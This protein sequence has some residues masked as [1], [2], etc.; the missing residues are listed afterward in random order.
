VVSAVLLLFPLF[1]S[2]VALLTVAVLSKVVAAV[3]SGLIFTTRLKT[4][5]LPE[6]TLGFVQVTVKLLV[7]FGV[8][9]V[10]AGGPEIEIETKLMPAGIGSLKLTELALLGPAL[11]TSIV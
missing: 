10:Q 4:S 1:G 2:E 11:V 8:W 9:H 6:G 5:S 3:A 7:L